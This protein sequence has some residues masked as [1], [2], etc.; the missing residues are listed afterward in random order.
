MLSN[1]PTRAL[2]A[3]LVVF[4]PTADQ[5]YILGRDVFLRTHSPVTMR[6]FHNDIPS[7][8]IGEDKLLEQLLDMPTKPI[9]N[10]VYILYA[11]PGSGK[12]EVMR[13]LAT[14]IEAQAPART[15][16][17]VRISRTELDALSISERF[18]YLLSADSFEE[19]THQRW[20]AARQKPRTLSKLLVLSALESLL[21]S[22]EEINAMFYRLL[23][24]VQPYIE[25]SLGV[26]D[27]GNELIAPNAEL[28]SREEWEAIK[29][30][31]SLSIRLEYEQF[32]RQMLT[33]FRRHLLEG[34]DLPDTLRRISSRVI[35]QRGLRPILLVDDLVQSLNL[36]ATDLLDYFIT[37]EE[38]NWDVVLGLT[39]AAFETSQ[40]GRDLLQRIAYLDTIDDRVEKLWLSDE[41]GHDSYVLTEANCHH[42]AARYLAEYRRLTGLSD[43]L[44]LYPFNREALVRI[45]RGLPA[46]KGKARYFLRHLRL[47]L[48]QVAQGEPLLSA[49]AQFA[50]TESVARCS[51]PTLAAICEL[52]GPLLPDGTVRSVTLPATLLDQFDLPAQDTVIA[53]EPLL[54]LKLH[55]EAITQVIDDEEKAAVRDWLLGRE[56]NRQLL[57]P[58]RQGLARLLR[59]VAPPDLIHRPSI[60]QPHGLLHWHK[61]YLNTQPPICLEEVDTDGDGIPV[62]REIGLPA[63]DLHRYATATGAEAR[64]LEAG[65]ANETGLSPVF[66]AAAGY[67]GRMMAQLEAELG[68]PLEELALGL[69][70][71]GLVHFEATMM[72]EQTAPCSP[73]LPLLPAK[74]P[75]YLPV[76]R[77]QQTEAWQEWQALF[78]DFFQ[79]R[80]NLYDGQRL[81]GLAQTRPFA[82]IFAAI[83]TIE[84][85]RIDKAYRW[86]KRLLVNAVSD[87]QG[88]IR[89]AAPVDSRSPLSPPAQLWLGRL[90][91]AGATGL[92]LTELP[93]PVLAELAE[94]TPELYH[95][96]QLRLTA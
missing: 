65:L 54:K 75:V 94:Y 27:D 38:G 78:D 93:L 84:S 67:Q 85:T 76:D 53:V 35:Q 71:W 28:L 63:F 32:R 9:G 10:R 86:G 16:V 5:R 89:Q 87:W 26:S 36:F 70:A 80:E 7:L 33:A 56:V 88:L 24:A 3:G 23:N 1:H 77:L 18:R 25:R 12:S 48:A 61:P 13:W 79:L 21:D 50:R 22:D 14:Q 34:L 47:I 6:R 17:T 43:Q 39:P 37:L 90:N 74:Y 82:E 4:A 92:P 73:L 15:E 72:A 60:A 83:V 52:Y 49:V 44:E 2:E 45:F 68:L 11:A 91:Q 8:E 96:L 64:E 30:E 41:A 57:H 31:S 66:F 42:F 95:R 55:R 69:Y 20:A 19:M 40:R 59:R 81:R 51:D 29:A 58:L 46:G 62:S